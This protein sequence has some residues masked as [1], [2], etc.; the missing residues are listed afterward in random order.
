MTAI[1]KQYL[2]GVLLFFGWLIQL[3][4][5]RPSRGIRGISSS[6]VPEVQQRKLQVVEE[7]KE[8]KEKDK[9]KEEEAEDEKDK[10]EI[11]DEEQIDADLD[12][13]A[14]AE[15][16]PEPEE[17]TTQEESDP[18]PEPEPVTDDEPNPA[19]DDEL[20]PATDDEPEPATDDEPEPA[21]DD[22]PE[23]ATDDETTNNNDEE[24]TQEE[25]VEEDPI[26]D[27]EPEETLSPDETATT[28]PTEISTVVPTF[29]DVVAEN[30]TTTNNTLDELEELE[31][32]VVSFSVELSSFSISI[33]HD[34]LIQK[35]PGIQVH[36]HAEMRRS[37]PN[38]VA[39]EMTFSSSTVPSRNRRRLIPQLLEYTEATAFFEGPPRHEDEDV[40]QLQAQILSDQDAIAAVIAANLETTTS[41]FTV[42]AIEVEA[43]PAEDA[44]T[45]NGI[46]GGDSSSNNEDGGLSTTGLALV[47]VAACVGGLV[48]TGV[49]LLAVKNPD[50][51]TQ[52]VGTASQYSMPPKDEVVEKGEVL[53]RTFDTEDTSPNHKASD[54]ESD[55]VHE[56]FAQSME[57]HEFEGAWKGTGTAPVRAQASVMRGTLIEK[58]S[59]DQSFEDEATDDDDLKRELGE[60]LS[61]LQ[62]SVKAAREKTQKLLDEAKTQKY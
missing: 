58:P 20:E 41:T 23:P 25:E 1:S 54:S 52:Q 36:L 30:E 46:S 37:L 19:T 15:E 4:A 53:N 9:N 43:I 45:A 49:C 12:E 24:D 48:F 17:E 28:S 26:T 29:I 35:D 10:E 18:E 42:S 3:E 34:E 11:E 50:P 57:E 56:K 2:L 16:E 40:L 33:D 8:D 21:T 5:L 55:Q 32:E 60:Q 62:A 7:R 22:E 47:L 38:I 13:E 61:D 51:R 14:E 39:I 6:P 31:A 27:D 44:G 59:F